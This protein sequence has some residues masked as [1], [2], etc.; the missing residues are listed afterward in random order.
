VNEFYPLS[1]IEKELDAAIE[2][3]V[4]KNGGSPAS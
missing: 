4:S 1:L 2:S 3:F